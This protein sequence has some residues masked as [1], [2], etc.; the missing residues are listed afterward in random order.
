MCHFNPRTPCGV[1]RQ[2]T[3]REIRLYYTSIHAPLAGCDRIQNIT[4]TITK[5]SIHAP[6][7]GCDSKYAQNANSLHER[8]YAK[9]SIFAY[10]RVNISLLHVMHTYFCWCEPSRKVCEPELR[11]SGIS[12]QSSSFQTSHSISPS[13]SV[14]RVAL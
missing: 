8:L 14:L 1:R 2:M 10:I 3:P 11:T 6:L 7:A 13:A 4:Q 5:T 12:Y 9:C